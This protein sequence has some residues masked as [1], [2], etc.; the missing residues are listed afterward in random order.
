[1]RYNKGCI[2]CHRVGHWDSTS[3]CYRAVWTFC[4]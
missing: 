4:R 2:S 3:Y 1:M